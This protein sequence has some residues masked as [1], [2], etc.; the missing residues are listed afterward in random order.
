MNSVFAT[1]Q[2]LL[3]FAVKFLSERVSS[4]KRDVQICIKETLPFPALLYCFATIDLLGSLYK[5]DATG[6]TRTYGNEVGT[7]RKARQYMIEIMKYPEYESSLLQD[8][9]RH[10]I[11]HLAQPQAVIF[12]IKNN[13]MIGWMLYNKYEGKHMLVEK[14]PSE[15]PVIV[16]TP[17]P[18]HVDHLFTVSIEKMVEDIEISINQAPNGYLERLRMNDDILQTKFDTAIKQIGL[19]SKILFFLH[20][21][22]LQRNEVL[23]QVYDWTFGGA[24]S[25]IFLKF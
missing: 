1:P 4:L 6:D 16:L 19:S 8:Q 9:F 18:V 3:D 17:Y 12:D 24:S 2:G 7:T 25:N 10:K 22:L 13:R 23:P 14:L 21:Y 15:Q 11:V 5:G 20:S